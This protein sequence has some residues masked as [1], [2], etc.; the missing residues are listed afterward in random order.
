MSYETL[1]ITPTYGGDFGFKANVL[2][3]NF[4]DGYSQTAANGIN[5]VSATLNLEWSCLS[6]NDKISLCE[7]FFALLAGSTPFYYTPYG[8]FTGLLWKCVQW[9][10][11]PLSKDLFRVTATL[12]Q[13]FDLPG[14]SPTPLRIADPN[15]GI[16]YEVVCEYG[17]YSCNPTSYPNPYTTYF[18]DDTT[19]GRFYALVCFAGVLDIAEIPAGVYV[20]PSNPSMIDQSNGNT[21]QFVSTNGVLGLEFIP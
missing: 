6:L 14:G 19:N 7:D 1:P 10:A 17:D 18:L 20:Q 3:N 12:E 15:T 9:G 16:V 21:Y 2:K 5:S 8:T 4:G 13:S 11:I